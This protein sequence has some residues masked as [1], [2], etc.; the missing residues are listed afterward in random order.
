MWAQ[1][2]YIDNLPKINILCWTLAH[3]NFLMG[4]DLQKRGIEE[5]FHCILCKHEEENLGNLFLN[6][7]YVQSVWGMTLQNLFPLINW[8][9]SPVQLFNRGWALYGGS[10]ENKRPII[11]LFMVVPKFVTSKIWLAINRATF[12]E[13]LHPTQLVANKCRGLLIE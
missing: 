11:Y 2:W 7:Q 13:V 10:L 5:P 4:E 1:I 3:G 9:A 12:L 8:P 6:Y